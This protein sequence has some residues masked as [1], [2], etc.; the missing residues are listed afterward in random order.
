MGVSRLEFGGLEVLD[1]FEVWDF[2]GGWLKYECSTPNGLVL[3]VSGF[4]FGVPGFGFRVSGWGFRA[5]GLGLRLRVSDC[6]FGLRL[7]S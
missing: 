4:G 7:Q 1:S 2:Q 6:G 5:S 3:W